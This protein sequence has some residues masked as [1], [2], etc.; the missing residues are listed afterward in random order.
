VTIPEE[1]TGGGSSGPGEPAQ[2]LKLDD[3]FKNQALPASIDPCPIQEAVI[4]LR[5]ELAQGMAWDAVP[6]LALT[7]LK[8]EKWGALTR[9]PIADVPRH[10]VEAE[11][12]LQF[13][14]HYS[15]SKEQMTLL[16]GPR[17]LALSCKPPYAG[18]N[19]FFREF[20]TVYRPFESEVIGR[21]SRIG[22][23]YIDAFEGHI[24]VQTQF[25]LAVDDVSLASSRLNIQ[26]PIEGRDGF[27]LLFRLAN[28]IPTIAG[29][30]VPGS[31][32][33]L[34]AFAEPKPFSDVLGMIESGHL[35]QK[36]L[37]FSVLKDDYL[38]TLNPTY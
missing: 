5:F 4:E 25:A 35:Q 27:Q 3:L 37:F 26:L 2:T 22:L 19:S 10:I 31:L 23:R 7:A 20:R 15:L 21:V 30:Q 24:L 17:V 38:K 1:L 6:G 11:S 18:W 28:G 16:L 32:I 29:K 8:G 36:E 9:L 13:S 12:D 33:D 14:P 34:D